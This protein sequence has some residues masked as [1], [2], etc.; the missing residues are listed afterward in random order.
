[1]SQNTRPSKRQLK[2]HAR[3]GDHVIGIV[4]AS[5]GNKAGKTG[6]QGNQEEK[7]VDAPNG[8]ENDA[9][10]EGVTVVED[11]VNNG[12]N[13]ICMKV[14][15]GDLK[16]IQEDEKR[17]EVEVGADIGQ[18]SGS[19][20]QNAEKVHANTFVTNAIANDNV[21][22]NSDASNRSFVR[23]SY[24]D[25]IASKLNE[26]DRKLKLIPTELDS[27]GVEVVVA[28]A[29]R[30]GKPLVMDNVTVSMFK[31]RLGRVGYARVLV[32]VDA[33][34]ELPED[35][36]IVYKNVENLEV[37][38]KSAKVMYDW[39]PLRCYKCCVFGHCLQNC[40]KAS[41]KE[42][43]GDI[44]G[45]VKG[46]S[47][48]NIIGTD[49]DGFIEAKKKKACNKGLG[50]NNNKV[51]LQ[52]PKMVYQPKQKVNPVS[53]EGANSKSV[54]GM[55]K[56]EDDVNKSWKDVF[57]NGKETCKQMNG[58]DAKRSDELNGKQKGT[59]KSKGVSSANKHDVLG[60]YDVYD[61]EELNEIR[62][63]VMV[64]EIIS[65]RRV[66]VDDD[67]VRWDID[68]VAYYKQKLAKLID[69]RKVVSPKVCVMEQGDVFKDDTGMAK[70]MDENVV[71]GMD[72]GAKQS[73]L[74]NISTNDAYT[75][76]FCSFV[77][78]AN[79][80]CERRVLWKDLEIYR[81]IVGKEPWVM[82][83]DMN[84]TLFPN[85][86]STGSSN[87]TSD[88]CKFRDCINMIEMED[89]ASSGL[90]YTWTKKT[91][92]KLKRVML[93]EF[94]KSLTELWGV[95]GL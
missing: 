12:T 52:Q 56:G 88:M 9:V 48:E 67:M 59:Q 46:K 63:Q 24:V 35:I 73:L 15:E 38:R 72:K 8:M 39:K 28:L 26:E 44:N 33:N 95:K 14:N 69:K 61:Q 5:N 43:K 21:K 27:N 31:S 55:K 90:F 76:M 86:H 92:L 75:R 11:V 94:S 37:Y 89:L 20:N 17:I 10:K 2:I 54:N 30:V 42:K 47:V 7:T 71:T 65:Q 74:C 16:S 85:E 32:E 80:G 19:G 36:E 78:A 60:K 41:S 79:D 50:M 29:S 66:L 87:M 45:N 3:L 18:T 58:K 93:V 91:C 4:G 22:N 57:N 83:G 68:M 13:D 82:M 77:Y 34:K 6:K 64:D 53:K 1:M 62:N 51:N 70:C 84:V 49:E 25:T 40:S 23:K 81:R